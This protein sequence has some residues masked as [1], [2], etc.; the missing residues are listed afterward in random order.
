MP[1]PSRERLPELTPKRKVVCIG[2]V[3]KEANMTLQEGRTDTKETTDLIA[4]DKV[5]GT[6]VYRS[7]GDHIGEIERVMIEGRFFSPWGF[8][9]DAAQPVA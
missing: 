9:L 3:T 4:S 6:E 5:E 1:Q 2:G 8:D 7:N